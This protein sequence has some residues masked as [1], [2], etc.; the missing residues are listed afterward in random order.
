MYIPFFSKKPDPKNSTRLSLSICGMHC[1]ACGL[2]IEGTL[3]DI[4]GVYAANA[5]YAGS[6]CDIVF[7]G[8]KVTKEVLTTAIKKLGYDCSEA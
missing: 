4:P 2:N 8:T 1:V 5:N 3:Q 6:H 7:D